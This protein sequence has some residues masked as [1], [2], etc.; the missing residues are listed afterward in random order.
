MHLPDGKKRV[1]VEHAHVGLHRTLETAYE[2][3][4]EWDS[5]KKGSLWL[6]EHPRGEGAPLELLD[7]QTNTTRKVGGDFV[8]DDWW[9]S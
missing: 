3:P 4:E 6:H 9:Y 1:R 5:N 8:I 2:T 7:P